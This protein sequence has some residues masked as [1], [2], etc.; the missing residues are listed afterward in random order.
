MIMRVDGENSVGSPA[1]RFKLCLSNTIGIKPVYAPPLSLCV[2]GFALFGGFSASKASECMRAYGVTYDYDAAAPL[3][4]N[5]YIVATPA[6]IFAHERIE[7]EIA[8]APV[9]IMLRSSGVG[10]QCRPGDS[11][12]PVACDASNSNAIGLIVC[13]PKNNSPTGTNNEVYA[14]TFPRDCFRLLKSVPTFGEIH[15]HDIAIR[16][17]RIIRP[18]LL[19]NRNAPHE[20]LPCT[21]KFFADHVAANSITSKAALSEVRDMHRTRN[22]T[23]KVAFCSLVDSDEFVSCVSKIAPSLMTCIQKTPDNYLL[24]RVNVS[25]IT[26][27]PILGTDGRSKK[28]KLGFRL[29]DGTPI[30]VLACHYESDA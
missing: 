10:F 6:G 3:A 23:R 20:L 29:H 17:S 24:Q 16:A 30:R 18:F 22:E 1:K 28:C 5:N 25:S 19:E 2:L 4:D 13:I 8:A 21:M 11:G 9:E 14:T 15:P 7:L 26:H 27:P 12:S